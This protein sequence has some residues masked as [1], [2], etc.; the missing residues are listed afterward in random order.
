MRDLIF[1]EERYPAGVGFCVS[2]ILWESKSYGYLLVRYFDRKFVFFKRT[3]E[4]FHA[5]WVVVR[6]DTK[7]AIANEAF[8]GLDTSVIGGFLDDILDER[9]ADVTLGFKLER[10]KYMK[11]LEKRG[12][13][14]ITN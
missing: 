3:K 9:E 8:N 6:D 11:E 1:Y 12:V 13:L 4:R 5:L 7:R 2:T 10:E 14:C